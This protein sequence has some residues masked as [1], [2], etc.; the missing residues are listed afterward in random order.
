M[1]SHRTK[2]NIILLIGLFIVNSEVSESEKQPFDFTLDDSGVKTIH[3]PPVTFSLHP[4]GT[5]TVKTLDCTWEVDLGGLSSVEVGV[6][7]VTR[8]GSLD[9]KKWHM[10]PY[11]KKIPGDLIQFID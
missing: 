7:G 5:L 8:H 6:T 3:F 4:N 10:P 1:V 2:F 11:E 9:C